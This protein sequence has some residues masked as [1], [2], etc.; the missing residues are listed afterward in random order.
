MNADAPKGA[1]ALASS[2]VALAETV[3]DGLVSLSLGLLGVALARWVF[4]NKEQRRLGRRESPGETLPLT[5]IAMLV[6]GVVI[7]EQ[8]LDL[9]AA[10]FT[11]LGVGWAAVILLDIL[12]DRVTIMLRSTLGVSAPTL[13]PEADLSGHEGRMIEEDVDIP[14]DMG[15]LIDQIGEDGRK[16]RRRSRNDDASGSDS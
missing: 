16:R 8:D 4:V 14:P 15:R 1:V 7:V 11:G 12:G 9:S 5:L 3:P 2:F 10:A 6:A 13:P